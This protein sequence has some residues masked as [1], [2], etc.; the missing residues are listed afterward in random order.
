MAFNLANVKGLHAAL[1]VLLGAANTAA[2]SAKKSGDTSNTEN[3][4]LKALATGALTKL[5]TLG[6]A[7]LVDAEVDSTGAP[8]ETA[9]TTTD[10]TASK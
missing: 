8:V 5:V 7:A 1:D 3:I 2:E 6:A 9:T 10:T 4:F